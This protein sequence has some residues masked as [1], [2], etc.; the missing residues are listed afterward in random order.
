MIRHRLTIYYLCLSW[1]LFVG[2]SGLFK[3]MRAA[4]EMK[5]Q[6]CSWNAKRICIGN[7]CSDWGWR[8]TGSW[9][10]ALQWLKRYWVGLDEIDNIVPC[11]LYVFCRCSPSVPQ[12]FPK[13]SPSVLQVFP[14]CSFRCSPSVPQVFSKC[15]SGVPRDTWGTLGEHLGNTWRT[16]GEH[17]EEHLEEH[18]RNQVTTGKLHS[19]QEHTERQ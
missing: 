14:K 12:V 9:R 17:S 5:I 10:C 19:I 6:A 18:L 16:L 8:C 13:C 1:S 15:S 2:E 4:L 3:W 11:V 7:R